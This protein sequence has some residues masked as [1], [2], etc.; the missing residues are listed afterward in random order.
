MLGNFRPHEKPYGYQLEEE[1][2]PSG[3]L[4]RGI[5]SARAKVNSTT[6]NIIYN[7]HTSLQKQ[8]IK[9]KCGEFLL[10]HLQ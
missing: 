7:L 2:L 6:A 5:Y 8:I 3:I 1:T 4:V 10:I 9:T